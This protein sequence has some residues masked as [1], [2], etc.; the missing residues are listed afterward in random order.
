VYWFFSFFFKIE[1]ILSYTDSKKPLYFLPRFTLEQK[2]TIESPKITNT[3][4]LKLKSIDHDLIENA[5]GNILA[6]RLHTS[7]VTIMTN[8]LM[9]VNIDNNKTWKA[10]VMIDTLAQATETSGTANGKIDNTR[11]DPMNHP[12]Y[13]TIVALTLVDS[14]LV[15]MIVGSTCGSANRC[16]IIV[17]GSS[18]P[19]SLKKLFLF[20]GGS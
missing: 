12:Q 20:A 19:L 5:L 8:K 14:C 1:H 15:D 7:P 2:T 4:I 16:S 13:T 9:S 17:T 11:R 18:W 10:T 3:T 6:P